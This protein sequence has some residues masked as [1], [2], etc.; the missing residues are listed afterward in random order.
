L[1]PAE[2]A[3][4]SD[5]QSILSKRPLALSRDLI[6]ICGVDAA[7]DGDRIFAAASLFESGRLSEEALCTGR[8]T[9][10]YVSGLFYLREG[11]FAVEAVRKLRL[12]PDLVC[13]DAHGAAHPR[14]AGLATTC[15]MVLGIPS[16]G[17]AKSRLVGSE[18]GGSNDQ[19]ERGR[20]SGFTTT[21]GG[22]KR[23]WS[24]GYSVTAASLRQIMKKNADVCLR[25]LFQADRCAGLAK[26]SSV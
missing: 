26:R 1:D 5:L 23:Y 3:F 4:F 19:G 18:P 15:G 20:S 21:I 9:L 12:R 7:Y 2:A 16:I 17:I 22:S 6:R 25:A 11:P 14:G 8:C 13:F 24:P 10:P